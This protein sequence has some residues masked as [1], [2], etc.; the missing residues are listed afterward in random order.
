MPSENELSP[1]NSAELMGRQPCNCWAL[2][3]HQSNLMAEKP[4][5][6]WFFS[7]DAQY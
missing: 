2:L 4:K 1:L 7:V 5:F 3:G 6:N